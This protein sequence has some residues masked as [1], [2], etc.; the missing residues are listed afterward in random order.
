M[1]SSSTYE[2]CVQLLTVDTILRKSLA[3]W[4]EPFP[5]GLSAYTRWRGE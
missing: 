3:L 1:S 2:A 4:K 5:M